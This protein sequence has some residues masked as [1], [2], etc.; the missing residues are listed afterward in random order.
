[1]KRQQHLTFKL[2]KI[3]NRTDGILT[4]ARPALLTVTI[5]FLQIRDAPKETL[6]ISHQ[7]A[8][9]SSFP[10]LRKPLVVAEEAEGSV[11]FKMIGTEQARRGGCAHF[12]RRE[13][14]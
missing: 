6:R 2:P 5:I 13:L 9:Q 3:A 4:A 12:E 1:M 14:K 10:G 8:S 11:G 7:V